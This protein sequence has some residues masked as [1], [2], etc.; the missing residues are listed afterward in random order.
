MQGSATYGLRARSGPWRGW[1]WPPT[2]PWQKNCQCNGG[3][4]ARVGAVEAVEATGL[5]ED[6][7]LPPTCPW[8]KKITITMAGAVSGA[9]MGAMGMAADLSLPPRPVPD[10]KN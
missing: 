7:S 3:A 10:Q 2:C 5:A 8:P 6:L 1:K 4:G 9:A